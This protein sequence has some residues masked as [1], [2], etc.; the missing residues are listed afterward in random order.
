MGRYGWMTSGT[1]G[2]N[3]RPTTI[4]MTS[5]AIPI[6]CVRSLRPNLLGEVDISN[7]TGR[8]RQ[9]VACADVDPD[10]V[11]GLQQ[12]ESLQAGAAVEHIPL[13][14]RRSDPENHI[15]AADRLIVDQDAAARLSDRHVRTDS[16]SAHRDRLGPADPQRV[17]DQL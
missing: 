9:A 6:I 10:A 17:D 1:L 4:P 5:A 2:W 16:H 15:W 13:R 11:A 8:Q 14:V 12:P 3:T 7:R